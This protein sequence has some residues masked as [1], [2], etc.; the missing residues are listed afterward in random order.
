[1]YGAGSLVAVTKESIYVTFNG[2]AG[3]Q[4]GCYDTEQAGENTFFC[5]KGGI[6]MMY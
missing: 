6:T 4:I 3:G 1:L 5:K 2:S